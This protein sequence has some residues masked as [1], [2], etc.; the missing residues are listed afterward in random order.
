MAAAFIGYVLPWGQMSFW[1]ATVIT[2]LFTVIPSN[3]G[4]SLALWLW[5][6][7]ILG[8]NTITRFLGMHFIVPYIISILALVHILSLH[9]VDVGSSNPLVGVKESIRFSS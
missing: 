2:N 6:G 4:S 1:G 7:F 8:S 5:G 3:I 9:Q